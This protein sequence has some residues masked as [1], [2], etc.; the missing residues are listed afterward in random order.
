MTS[1]ACAV[2]MYGKR[3]EQVDA[4]QLALAFS[5][6]DDELWMPGRKPPRRRS[7]APKRSRTLRHRRRVDAA[8]GHGR[9][10]LPEHLPRERRVIE[11]PPEACTCSK[12]QRPWIQ[13]GEET[14]EYLE[15]VPASYKVIVLVRPKFVAGCNC[16]DT[17]VVVADVPPRPIEKGKA[18]PGL[19][20]HIVVS[21]YADHLP[22]TRQC[23]IL[24]RQGIEL[25]RQTLC[26]WV[27]Q[28]ADL[29]EPIARSMWDSVLAS[30]VIHADETPVKVQD[31]DPH[32]EGKPRRRQCRTGYL[33]AYVGDAG[34]VVFDFTQDPSG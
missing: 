2:Q 33:W 26:D 7:A 9:T 32:E 21:K 29:L 10:P 4:A 15:H 5:A 12:C 19:L 34:D 14:S 18:G 27:R 11:P 20:A 13:I 6:L 3:S 8:R 28:V 1:I 30:R 25:S 31:H 17:G 22:L 16:E 23:E 24:A